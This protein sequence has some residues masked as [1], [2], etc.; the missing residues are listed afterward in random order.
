MLPAK[1]PGDV[2]ATYVRCLF[3]MLFAAGITPYDRKLYQDENVGVDVMHATGVD[4]S[5]VCDFFVLSVRC[6]DAKMIFGL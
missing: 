4:R 2:F 3:R 5:R 6:S 1:S